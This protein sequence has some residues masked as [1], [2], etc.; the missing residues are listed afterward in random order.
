MAALLCLV[1]VQCAHSQT[2]TNHWVGTW[3]AS[4][5]QANNSQGPIGTADFTLR[6]NVH[7]S[8]PGKTVRIVVSNEMGTAPLRLGGASI[9]LNAP[10]AA[11]PSGPTTGE[12]TIT[13]DGK[14]SATVPAGAKLF[15]DAID[16]DL[17]AGANLA[18][19]LFIPK[20]AIP[21]LTLHSFGN[22]PNFMVEGDQIAGEQKSASTS[23]PPVDLDSWYFL[24]AV[25]VQAP[26]KAASIVT[27]GDSITDGAFSTRGGNLRWPDDLARRLQSSPKTAHLSVLN[28]GI[29]GNRI[30]HPENGTLSVPSALARFDRDVLSQAGVKYLIILEGINDIGIGTNPHNPRET[31]SPEDLAYALSQLV[32][33][34]HTHGIKVYLGTVMPDKGLGLY[35][36]EAGETERQAVNQWIRA[37]KLSDG[38]IDFDRVVR[39]PADPQRLLPALDHDHIHPNDAGHQAMADAIDLSWFTR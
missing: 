34:A 6:E 13:F 22:Q 3:A 26:A 21:T 9:A 14:T 30:L 7:A 8:I 17:P 15:S 32:E 11:S 24:T 39:D 5:V 12:T 19:R 35:Y 38:V 16:F 27:L 18:I 4:P 25:E 23:T 2:G 10:D 31:V 37:N 29:G 33:R 1:P 36:S 28:E 20:Q